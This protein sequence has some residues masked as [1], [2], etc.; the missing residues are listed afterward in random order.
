MREGLDIIGIIKTVGRSLSHD[1]PFKYGV[2]IVIPEGIHPPDQSKIILNPIPYTEFSDANF[3]R[4]INTYIERS[5]EEC[6]GCP[7]RRDETDKRNVV[8]CSGVGRWNEGMVAYA[9][10]TSYQNLQKEGTAR[11]LRVNNTPCSGHINVSI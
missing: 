7:L 9:W 2:E 6:Q 1:K 11:A 8:W 3:S 10:V 4:R 5:G